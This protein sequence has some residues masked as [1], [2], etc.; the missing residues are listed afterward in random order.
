MRE[1]GEGINVN[2]TKLVHA[3]DAALYIQL[4][5]ERRRAGF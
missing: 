4:C 2:S 5:I 3:A 1:E